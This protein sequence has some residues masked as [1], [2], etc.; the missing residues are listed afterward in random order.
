MNN[1]PFDAVG[2]GCDQIDLFNDT[3]KALKSKFTI[4]TTGHINFQLEQFDVFKNYLDINLRGSLVIKHQSKESY[5]LFIENHFRMPGGRG[6]TID[7]HECQTWALAFLKKDFGR[8][9][10]RRETLAD[11]ILELVHP[12]ELDFAEDKPFSDTFYVLVND[13]H[14][15]VE[16]IN[17]NFRNAVMDIRHDDF[18]I[19]I[20]EHTLIIGDQKPV[21]PERAVYLAEFVARLSIMC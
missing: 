16:A 8:V 19:E 3:Y 2:L 6:P 10:I 11:K 12:V 5:I 13:H 15:A 20:M 18:V 4:E 14:K 1:Y 21:S 17:R 9:L 7:T